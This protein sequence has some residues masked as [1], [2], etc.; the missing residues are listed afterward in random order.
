LGPPDLDGL[1]TGVLAP[2]SQIAVIIDPARGLLLCHNQ[3][4]P[5]AYNGLCFRLMFCKAI[6]RLRRLPVSS[7]SSCRGAIPKTTIPNKEIAGPSEFRRVDG[8]LDAI[9]VRH[10]ASIVP[11]VAV[12]RHGAF[13]TVVQVSVRR[14]V[15]CY[16]YRELTRSHPCRIGIPL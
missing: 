12:I 2:A 1:D 6:G 8:I 13:L 11:V 5:V 9:F 16:S 4:S 15:R 14:W 7:G 3:R 10:A